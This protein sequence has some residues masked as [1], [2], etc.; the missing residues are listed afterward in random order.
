LRDSALLA[1]ATPLLFW[2][3]QHPVLRTSS[4]G[5]NEAIGLILGL[6]LPWVALHPLTRLDRWWTKAIVFVGFLPLL[7][8][9]GFFIL[10]ASGA[11]IDRTGE[12]T[13]QRTKIAFYRTDGGATTDYGIIV[14]Q[15][16]VLLPGILL[17]RKLDDFY[18][19]YAVHSQATA[20]GI[21]VGKS[22]E[23]CPG[24]SRE[25][26]NSSRSSTSNV[27]SHLTMTPA[28]TGGA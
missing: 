8:Y 14:R 2:Q 5:F 4:A 17:V 19:C 18:P 26:I 27:Q 12:I 1:L 22:Q 21:E 25:N 20:D 10:V 9:S 3:F 6:V 13:W 11:R 24:L 28:V 23:Y 16:R 7:I 15:E